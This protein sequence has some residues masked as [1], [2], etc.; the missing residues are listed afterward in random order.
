ME[1]VLSPRKPLFHRPSATAASMRAVVVLIGLNA[2]LF[3]V[4]TV[5][6]IQYNSLA[7]LSDAGNSLIDIVT[8]VIILLAV[9][10]TGKPADREHPFGHG[11]VE[12]VAAFTV[13][14]L[15]CMLATE[16][17]RE[18][19]GRLLEGS[20]PRTG[21]IP[22]LV[23]LGVVVIKGAIWVVAGRMGRR[24]GSAALTAAAVDAQMDVVISLMAL[25]GVAGV[26]FHLP[27][28]D[29]AASLAIS[30]WIAWVGY[31]L[32]RD[33]IEKLIGH[34]PDATTV[35]L[36]RAKLDIM[37]KSGKIRNFHELRIHYVGSEI[38]LAV[39]VDVNRQLDMQ[40]SHDLDEEIQ[41]GL[42]GVRGVTH[43]A[44]HI[45]PV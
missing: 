21:L 41:A 22:I 4:K 33:N 30:F 26:Y 11:R 23:L 1:A 29:G 17:G 18:A 5:V 13:A 32:G 10:E 45:D 25:L 44:V 14:I 2:L 35:R 40:R 28:L 42:M 43:V 24:Q 34:L 7:I 20:A 12:P 3:V 15:T 39:H 6:G 27:W 8:S 38:H 31:N 19:V 16:V 36:I 9:R 37:K